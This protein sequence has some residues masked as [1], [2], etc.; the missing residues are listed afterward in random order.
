M[1]T[2][3]QYT[4]FLLCI[5]VTW[6]PCLCSSKHRAVCMDKRGLG[7]QPGIF[8]LSLVSNLASSSSFCPLLTAQVP[9]GCGPGSWGC[10][11]PPWTAVPGGQ[12]RQAGQQGGREI[13][14]ESC[15]AR[16]C[17]WPAQPRLRVRPAPPPR[18]GPPH[19]AFCTHRFC[20]V[21]WFRVPGVASQVSRPIHIP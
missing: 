19:S 18:L 7:L 13:V 14:P 1:D 8:F 16:Q 11:G 5:R 15:Q 4:H 10:A 3:G 6:Q 2:L 20:A 21:G 17:S 12:R 9:K